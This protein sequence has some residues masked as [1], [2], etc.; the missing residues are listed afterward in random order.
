RCRNNPGAARLA[1]PRRAGR[2]HRLAGP[3]A[4][5]ARLRPAGPVLMP[6]RTRAGFEA[7]VTGLPAVTLHEQWGSLVAKVGGKVFALVGENGGSLTFKVSETSFAGLTSIAGIGQAPYFA[8]GQWV[9]V[10]AGAAIAD[11][12]LRAYVRES[13]RMIAGK[14]TRKARAE[15]GLD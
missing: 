2:V 15:L 8:R 12:D 1:R 7:F 13:H 14:L 11:K 6:V 9:S 3:D 4:P 10:G 5:R